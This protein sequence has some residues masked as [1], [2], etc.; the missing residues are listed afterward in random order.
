MGFSKA[1]HESI[2]SVEPRRDGGPAADPAPE[3]PSIDGSAG[4]TKLDGP[5]AADLGPASAPV[6][7]SDAQLLPDLA[8]TSPTS[9][10]GG[11]VQ[12]AGKL[13]QRSGC[14]CRLGEERTRGGLAIA[15]L[16]ATSCFAIR[17]R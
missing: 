9:D 12:P 5:V 14:S 2:A 15:L 8:P 1:C 11:P 13:A 6:E 17:R 3:P 16:L 10:S 4:E 7:V